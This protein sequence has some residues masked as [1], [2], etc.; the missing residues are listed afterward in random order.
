MW[1]ITR[2]IIK[3]ALDFR[4]FFI[5]NE[6]EQWDVDGKHASSMQVKLLKQPALFLPNRYCDFYC[7]QK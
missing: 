6:N 3:K 2:N 1:I 4:A 5:F 7:F